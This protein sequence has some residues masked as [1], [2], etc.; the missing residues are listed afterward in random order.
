ML[1]TEKHYRAIEKDSEQQE[2]IR[3]NR[4]NCLFLRRKENL[5]L[6]TR[7]NQDIFLRI[8]S[9]KSQYTLK[10]L[11]S[12]FLKNH[13]ISAMISKHNG[14]ASTA[15]PKSSVPRT[16]LASITPLCNLEELDRHLRSREDEI[17][18]ALQER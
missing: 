3:E 8:Q 7:A 9:Q 12:E 15:R 14:G 2:N 10:K 1:L 6:M 17:R 4:L 18:Q 16:P 13:K 11:R 5:K